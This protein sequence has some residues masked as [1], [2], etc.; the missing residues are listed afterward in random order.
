M[1]LKEFE[2]RGSEPGS[3]R[4]SIYPLNVSADY[5]ETGLGSWIQ[6]Q[7]TVWSTTAECIQSV[8]VHFSQTPPTNTWA[9]IPA[10]LL[11]YTFYYFYFLFF[12]CFVPNLKLDGSEIDHCI[13]VQF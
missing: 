3:L 9:R 6:L 2:R 11:I 10:L 4:I 13:L 8:V 1:E 12:C 5:M 7:Q